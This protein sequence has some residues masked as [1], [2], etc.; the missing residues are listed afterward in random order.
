[1]T[2][3]QALRL[4]PGAVVT[5]EAD[6]N[7]WR[8]VLLPP[9]AAGRCW[10]SVQLVGVYRKPSKPPQGDLGFPENFNLVSE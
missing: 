4:K 6:D 9:D 7:K 5:F 8:G 10:W 1:M 2:R 3:E